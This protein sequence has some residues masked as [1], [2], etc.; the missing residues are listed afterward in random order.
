MKNL[1]KENKELI[2]NA[3]TVYYH[4]GSNI[5]TDSIELLDDETQSID[6]DE[7]EFVNLQIFEKW[8]ECFYY[9]NQ[10]ESLDDFIEEWEY[11]VFVE[12]QKI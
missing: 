5:H 4:I 2:K 6:F 8:D 10:S 12:L 9:S 11:E 1:T 3:N 7:Y